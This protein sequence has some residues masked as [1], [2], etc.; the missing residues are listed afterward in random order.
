MANQNIVSYKFRPKGKGS[1][2][3]V[4]ASESGGSWPYFAN[5]TALLRRHTT[6]VFQKISSVAGW[7]GKENQGGWKI[8][9]S[10]GCRNYIIVLYTLLSWQK[11]VCSTAGKKTVI[12]YIAFYLLD[13]SLEFLSASSRRRWASVFCSKQRKKRKICFK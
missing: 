11:P 7:M 13:R 10:S 1:A 3:I 12:E 8:A 6:M 4:L 5:I 2:E 9:L